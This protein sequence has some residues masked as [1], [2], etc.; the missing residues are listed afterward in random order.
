MAEPTGEHVVRGGKTGGLNRYHYS[1]TSGGA[2]DGWSKVDDDAG[3]VGLAAENGDHFSD[4]QGRGNAGHP[5]PG[6]QV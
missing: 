6:S 2:M 3:E 1:A 5:Q 4:A